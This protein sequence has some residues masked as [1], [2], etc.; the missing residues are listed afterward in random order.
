M[1]ETNYDNLRA[2]GATALRS[3]TFPA[4]PEEYYGTLEGKHPTDLEWVG[5]ELFY[6]TTTNRLFIQTAT[7]GETATWKQ[8]SDAFGTSTSTSTSS[9]TSTTSTT[10][11][12]SSSSS[13]SSTTSS[14]SSSTST[15]TSTSSST[16]T[17]T[18]T[19]STTTP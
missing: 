7:S 1:S 6:Y 17:S 2:R 18:S 10:S 19:S 4:T 15:S 5:G 12:T 16:S 13:T 14:T 9:S 3:S 8:M 11:S